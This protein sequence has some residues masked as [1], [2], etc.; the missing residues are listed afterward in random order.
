[1][2]LV[3]YLWLVLD[4]GTLLLWS[5]VVHE[6][7]R[8]TLGETVLYFSHFLREVP[9]AVGYALFLLGVSGGA[10]RWRNVD[11]RTVRRAG[12]ISVL[13]AGG[14]VLAALLLTAA[15]KGWGYALQDLFQYHM[16]DDLWGYG[17]HWRYH[18]L[19]TLWFGAAVG[20]APAL[21]SR[22]PGLRALHPHPFWMRMAWA[23]FL[24]FTLVFGVA[25]DIFVDPRFAGHQA[26][27]IMT[28][29]PVT[30][31]LGIGVLLVTRA[32]GALLGTERDSVRRPLVWAMAALS[33][34]VPAYLAIVSFGGNIMEQGQSELGL[35]AMV[36]AHFFEHT[37]DFLFFLLLLAGGLALGPPSSS[38]PPPG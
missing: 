32:G 35:G 29:G 13:M 14:L 15:S 21:A 6:S 12:W 38:H 16:R 17:S 28:H 23:Y 10:A 22:I 3:S 37:L 27:E 1:M 19:S 7:G 31:L 18:W 25:A 34:L 9:I 33:L 24:V 30:L 8:Y 4:H 11:R 26:R 36:G 5:V 2:L 20:V